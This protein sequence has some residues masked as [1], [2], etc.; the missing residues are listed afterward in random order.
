M[1]DAYRMLPQENSS[2]KMLSRRKGALPM[3]ERAST[4]NRGK[5]TELD[6]CSSVECHTPA[7]CPMVHAD[8]DIALQGSLGKQSTRL[9]EWQKRV[10][11]A[12]RNLG[13]RSALNRSPLVRLAYVEKLAAERYN[14]RLLPRGLALHDLLL[15]CVKKVSVELA[16]EP[17]LTRACKYLQLLIQGLSCQEI[18]RQLGLSREHVSRVCRR[19]ALELVTEEFLSTVR[20]SG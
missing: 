7:P 4:N 19:K 15:T 12:L 6:R 3:V 2:F 16:D 9:D 14:G 17:G 8:D 13:D 1:N 20:N 18:S 5:R 10:G 11:Q